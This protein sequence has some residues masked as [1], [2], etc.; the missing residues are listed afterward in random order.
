MKTLAINTL[1]LFAA[2]LTAAI[3]QVQIPKV[4]KPGEFRTLGIPPGKVSLLV[5]AGEQQEIRGDVQAAAGLR[6]GTYSRYE[7]VHLQPPIL[8][9]LTSSESF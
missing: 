2:S 8:R 5:A 9:A 7:F 4:G 1:I 3:L 6:S